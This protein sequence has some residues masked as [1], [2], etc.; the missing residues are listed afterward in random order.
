MGLHWLVIVP[1]KR[2][3][4]EDGG[5]HTVWATTGAVVLIGYQF[6][7]QLPQQKSTGSLKQDA[8]LESTSGSTT[9]LSCPLL[10]Q[11]TL[12][13]GGPDCV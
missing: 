3:C 8:L 5:P 12:E 10:L 4:V 9:F 11:K 7:S 1:N 13:S 2:Q 6:V